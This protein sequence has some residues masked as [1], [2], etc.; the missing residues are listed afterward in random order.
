MRLPPRPRSPTPAAG[1]TA[2]LA[3]GVAAAVLG[4]AGC[5]DGDVRDDAVEAREQ[6]VVEQ[7][8]VRYRVMLFRELNVHG[9]PD[10]AIWT[11]PPPPRGSGLYMAVLEACA[12]GD[13]AARASRD[14]HLEDAF[15][16]RFE[17][18]MLRT[19][20]TFGYR[21]TTIQPGTCVPREGSPAD[22]TLGGAALVFSV[23]FDS[24]RE[25]PMVLSLGDA[26]I[27]LDL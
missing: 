7:D 17:P 12:T 6:N 23:P 2:L 13:G 18:R 26:R 10:S 20:D 16:E 21:A 1:V 27:E 3:L 14:V 11:G 22:H 19:D 8:G 15:G 9:F 25:R 24:A 4:L 5:G